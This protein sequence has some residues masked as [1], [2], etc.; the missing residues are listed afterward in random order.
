ML[1]IT[2]GEERMLEVGLFSRGFWLPAPETAG[3]GAAGA[4][5]ESS[6]SIAS[7]RWSA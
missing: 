6:L 2:G 1:V 3:D 4:L 7:A 5:L